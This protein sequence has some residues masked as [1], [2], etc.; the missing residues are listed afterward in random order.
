MGNGACGCEDEA[1]AGGDD[2]DDRGD[3]ERSEKRKRLETFQHAFHV[4]FWISDVTQLNLLP[5]S[6][7]SSDGS[8]IVFFARYQLVYF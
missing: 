5:S 8:F 1:E 7:I 4:C 3:Q 6:F 2:D